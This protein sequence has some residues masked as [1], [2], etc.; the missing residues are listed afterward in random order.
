M[1]VFFKQRLV[2]LPTLWGLVIILLILTATVLFAFKNI[3][4]YLAVNK[5]VAARYLIVEGWLGEPALLEAIQVFNSGA[6]ELLITTGGP[7]TR[8]VNPEYNSFA[9]KSAA[10]IAESGFD[11]HK[12]IIIPTPASAQDRTYLSAVMVR[13]WFE[14]QAISPSIT[15]FSGD[16]H[17]R[18]TH[19]L[20]QMAFNDDTIGIISASPNDFDLQSWWQT[21]A[22][23]KSVLTES[24]G[25]VWTWCCFYPGDKG[26]HQE[27]W[28]PAA[29]Y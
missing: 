22:G 6:Y 2:W 11:T 25:L 4:F 17:A 5:P 29:L 24:A 15:L 20:Y 21:S 18:R 23:A 12:L 27:K 3:A 16:V 9:E 8:R 13:D 28:G 1:P 14:S 7:D 10:F 19:L 26:S